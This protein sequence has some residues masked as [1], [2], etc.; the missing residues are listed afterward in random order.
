MTR[1]EKNKQL[2]ALSIKPR[3]KTSWMSGF[4]IPPRSTDAE[5][6]AGERSRL[7]KSRINSKTGRKNYD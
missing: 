6:M 2:D 7:I 4:V 3:R 5:V 1:E